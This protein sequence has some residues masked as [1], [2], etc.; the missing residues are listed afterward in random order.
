MSLRRIAPSAFDAR[1]AWDGSTTSHP[2]GPSACR[3]GVK[4]RRS[5]ARAVL[6]SPAIASRKPGRGGITTAGGCLMPRTGRMKPDAIRGAHVAKRVVPQE[7]LA[8]NLAG[9]TFRFHT[10]SPDLAEYART[11]LGPLMNG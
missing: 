7:P 10:D 9:A 5:F 6:D 3:E 11:H 4:C 8:G 2:A 1:S